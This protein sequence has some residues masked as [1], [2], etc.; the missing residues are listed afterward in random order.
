MG[1]GIGLTSVNALV[2]IQ[3]IVGWSQ[4]C[5]ATASNQFARSLGGP[6]GTAILYAVLSRSDDAAMEMSGRLRNIL[7]APYETAAWSEG[8]LLRFPQISHVIPWALLG[9]SVAGAFC[10][11][12]VPADSCASPEHAR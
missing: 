8:A 2:L 10:A 5:E 1:L 12:C 4:R 9:V 7:A 11:L 3:G 6:I